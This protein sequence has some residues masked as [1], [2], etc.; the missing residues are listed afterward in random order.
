MPADSPV[1]VAAKGVCETFASH[2]GTDRVTAVSDAE[3]QVRKGTRL[4][5]VGESGSGK[6]TLVRILAGLTPPDTGSVGIVGEPVVHHRRGAGQAGTRGP[7]SARSS[8]NRCGAT[9]AVRRRS[10]PAEPRSCWR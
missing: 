5:I 6:T 7:R 8:A 9:S 3:F 4:G 10:A 2:R 1:V